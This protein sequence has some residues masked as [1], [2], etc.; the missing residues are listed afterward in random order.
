MAAIITDD[1]RRNA[2]QLL[3]SDVTTGGSNY[4]MGIGKSDAYDPDSAGLAETDGSFSLPV[5]AASRAEE[6]EVLNNLATLSKVG[7]NSAF[8]VMPRVYYQGS[9]R[10]KVYDPN[11]A[12]CFFAETVDGNEFEPC[13]VINSDLEV[14]ICLKN[15]GTTTSNSDD[16]PTMTATLNDIFGASETGKNNG[17]ITTAE[18][19][20]RWAY[21]CTLNRDSGFFTTQF[22]AI[23]NSGS[24]AV[25]NP[26]LTAYDGSANPSE[27]SG[28]LIYGFKVIDGGS[29][30]TAGDLE[31]DCTGLRTDGTGGDNTDL[32]QFNQ[33]ITCTITVDV[34]GVITQCVTK[35]S[36]TEI[37]TTNILGVVNANAVSNDTALSQTGSGAILEPMI[38]PLEGVGTDNLKL[39]PS[40]YCGIRANFEDDLG[41]DGLIIPFRQVS[42]LKDPSLGSGDTPS[43][44]SSY[45]AGDAAKG[46]R[47]VA[48]SASLPADLATGDILFADGSSNSTVQ[49]AIT[50]EDPIAIFDH[51]DTTNNRLYYHQNFDDDDS[52]NL[53]E[54]NT[55]GDTLK[56]YDKSAGAVSS[57]TIAYTGDPQYPEFTI[58]DYTN[59][60][61][62]SGTEKFGQL[63][64]DVLFIENRSSVTRATDQI[65]EVRMIIQF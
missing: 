31:V 6:L 55:G 42:L 58:V 23:G 47:Y 15:D 33:T 14:F 40:Y 39:L 12:N 29:G 41:G 3:V 11:D 65:E 25:D 51:L 2:A 53:L 24:S 43:A 49:D 26:A 56:W 7:T 38:L 44:T 18:D 50:N 52:Q 46:L 62:S 34:S 8:R 48:C 36:S 17:L 27:T 28:G 20:F 35:L 16:E 19:D 1:F 61:T 4:Y 5:P 13:Y 59:A 32:A 45:A 64:G 9:K 54:L 60:N 22:A 21:V 37:N 30:Y 57:N 63:N 10:Y